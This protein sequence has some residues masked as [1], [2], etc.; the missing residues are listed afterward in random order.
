MYKRLID[1]HTRRVYAHF[2]VGDAEPAITRFADQ[3]RLVFRG[4]SRLAADLRTK[5]DIARW[6]R[7]LMQ[8]NLCWTVHDVVVQGPPW[9]TRLATLFSVYSNRKGHRHLIYDGV[10][11]A[12]LKWGR[13]HLDDIL[14][15]TQAL[16]NYL[17][18]GHE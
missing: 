5:Q 8:L 16:E 13:I 6:L 17:S 1:H 14:P 12:R 4:R 15:D 10:Q 11:Y 9:N 18:Q 7:E 2:N 3:A